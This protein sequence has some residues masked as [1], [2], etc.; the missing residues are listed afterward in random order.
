MWFPVHISPP[1]SY[2]SYALDIYLDARP[3]DFGHL[4][5]IMMDRHHLSSCRTAQVTRCIPRDMHP[6]SERSAVPATLM[7][8]RPLQDEW[9]A[10]SGL[11]MPMRLA[12]FEEKLQKSIRSILDHAISEHTH[13]FTKPNRSITATGYNKSNWN[14]GGFQSI[15]KRSPYTRTFVSDFKTLGGVTLIAGTRRPLSY[16]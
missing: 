14:S 8:C 1:G 11:Y 3:S 15:W 16:R 4:F 12:F 2:L 10:Y 13:T 9:R 5:V 6:A 7:C